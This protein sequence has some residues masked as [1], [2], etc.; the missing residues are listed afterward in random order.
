M[1]WV[2]IGWTAV[3]WGGRVRNVVEASGGAAD[4]V[5]PA[6]FVATAVYAAV[7]RKRGVPA[8]ALLT[9]AVWFVRLPL[10]L[11]HDRSAAFKLVHVTL[12]AVSLGLAYVTGRSSVPTVGTT[13][14]RP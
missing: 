1:P 2:F 11:V 8:L 14:S 4:L 5:V 6:A 7:D 9:A 3:V 13:L 12:A 10:V